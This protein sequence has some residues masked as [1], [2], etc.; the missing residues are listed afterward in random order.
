MKWFPWANSHFAV[1]KPNLCPGD[2]MLV[3]T[4]TGSIPPVTPGHF[5]HPLLITVCLMFPLFALKRVTSASSGRGNRSQHT[6]AFWGEFCGVWVCSWHFSSRVSPSASSLPLPQVLRYHLRQSEAFQLKLFPPPRAFGAKRELIVS[7]RRIRV[8]YNHFSQQNLSS[9]RG[10][11]AD[12][13]NSSC[14]GAVDE[15][16]LEGAHIPSSA[17][18]LGE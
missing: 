10:L 7:S 8:L 2:L 15:L 9:E 1:N 11:T 17:D 12:H 6:A 4:P 13:D 16:T 18:A 5:T 3:Q 14:R